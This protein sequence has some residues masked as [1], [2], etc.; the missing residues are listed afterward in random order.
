MPD[1]QERPWSDNPNAPKIPYDVYY[2]EKTWFAGTLISSIL[3]GAYKVSL[4]S[5]PPLRAHCTF[6]RF[7]VGMLITLF[8]NCMAALFNPAFRRGE[9]IK[10]G[11]VTYTVI[12]FSLVTV[13][14]AMKDH[15]L[16][17]CYI[18][19][20]DFPDGGPWGYHESNSYSALFIIARAA[21]NLNN[22]M[23][24]GLLVS[25]L[26]IAVTTHPGA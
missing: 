8:F 5:L 7:T 4:P 3:Y 21:F 6:V 23:A 16:S 26:I 12:M 22:W 14:T 10:W 9:G 25:S 11:L 17:I 24:D 2:A 20:R 13:Y 19:N 1:S 18:D 15:I